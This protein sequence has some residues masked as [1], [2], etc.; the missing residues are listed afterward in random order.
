MRLSNGQ[1]MAVML[2]EILSFTPEKRADIVSRGI[3]NSNRFD[4]QIMLDRIE[5]IY[6]EIAGETP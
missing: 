2:K 3:E 4:P 1:R 5:N 6:K